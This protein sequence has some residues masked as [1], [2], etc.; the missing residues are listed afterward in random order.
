MSASAAAALAAGQQVCARLH[1]AAQGPWLAV[2]CLQPFWRSE[3]NCRPTCVLLT[4]LQLLEQRECDKE[5]A[6]AGLNCV[7]IVFIS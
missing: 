4:T 3:G 1:R 7:C 5:T 6:F 2:C